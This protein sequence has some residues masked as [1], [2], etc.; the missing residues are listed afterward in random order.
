MVICILSLLFP[1]LIFAQFTVDKCI[2]SITIH[3]D[4]CEGLRD[5]RT[6]AVHRPS[7]NESLFKVDLLREKI[8]MFLKLD[9]FVSTAT[10]LHIGLGYQ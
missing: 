7:V 9:L 4:T 3:C 1:S 8:E 5:P 2:N 6:K 10:D